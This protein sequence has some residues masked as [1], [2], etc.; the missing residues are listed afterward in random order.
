MPIS[1]FCTPLNIW[2][3]L[4]S[5]RFYSTIGQSTQKEFSE[6]TENL[7]PPTAFK[8]SLENSRSKIS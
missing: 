1:L 6:T 5:Q 8:I 4:Q 7:L 3:L 2:Y